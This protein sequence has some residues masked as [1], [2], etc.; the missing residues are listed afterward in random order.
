[1]SVERPDV[2]TIRAG[3]GLTL[4]CGVTRLKSG[5]YLFVGLDVASG[6]EC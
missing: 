6:P 3:V 5:S 1:M 2:N 4:C